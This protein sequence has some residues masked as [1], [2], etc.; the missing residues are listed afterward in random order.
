[1]VQ[2]AG[3]PEDGSSPDPELF[4]SYASADLDRA[5]ALQARLSGAGF[6]V[7]FD[8]ARLRPGCNWHQEIESACEAASVVVPLLTPHWKTSEWTRFET[9]GHA[10]ILALLAEGTPDEI[11]TP[12][13]KGKQAIS[14]DPL[15]ANDAAWAAL[16]TAL[17]DLLAIPRP[18]REPRLVDLPYPANPYFAGRD[19]ELVRIHEELHEAPAASL[20]QGRVRVLVGMG[21]IGKTTLANEYARRFWRLYPQI[22]WIDARRG[23]QSEFALIFDEFF[24]E[25]A[26]ATLKPEEKAAQALAELNGPRE[27]LLVIDNAEDAGSVRPWLPR[28]ATSGCRTLIT[29]RFS[30]WAQAGD[31]RTISLDVLQPEPSRR[32]LLTRTGRTADAAE[33]D[34]CD[35][36]A[37][38]LGYLPLALEQAAA[39]VG[40]AGSGASFADY[41]RLY[42]AAAGDLLA[43]GEL[44]STEYPDPVITTWQTSLAKL[45]PE[46]RAVLRL[47][48][49]L[50]DTPI[51]RSLVLDGA[52]DVLA[53]AASFG[54]VAPPAGE[55]ATELR[56]RDAVIGLAR[57]SMV[58][59]GTDT[60]FRVHGLVQTVERLRAAADGAEAAARGHALAR[61]AVAFPNAFRDPSCWPLCRLLLPH[62]RALSERLGER[63]MSPEQAVL[64]NRTG[65]FLRET[66][67]AAAALPLYRRALESREQMLGAEHPDTL[68]SVSNLAFCLLTLGD[69]AAALPLYRRALD[70][71]ETV[72]GAGDPQTLTCL[73]NVASCLNSLGDAKAALPLFVRA[74]MGLEHVLGP[75][76]PDTLDSLNNLAGCLERLGEPAAAL[77]LYRRAVESSER[78]LGAEH[79]STLISVNNLADCLQKLGDGPAALALYVRTLKSNARVLGAE[80][81]QTLIC[82]NNLGLCLASCGDAAAAVPLIGRAAEIAE[83]TLGTDHPITRQLRASLVQAGGH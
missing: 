52:G 21:G 19:A 46:S 57:Y 48:A 11:L 14:L 78:V 59:D 26:I 31:T 69:A 4:I 6:R 39:Y 25:R 68:I 15:T 66:G 13:L 1:M 43:R 74:L 2:T 35:T 51:P 83:R 16:A 10:A 76:H 61:L 22:L 27:R 47:C 54:P 34:A 7:W 60:S 17:H 49:W 30:G 23:Y 5:A 65:N 29:S 42:Q 38:E 18:E 73:N 58:L 45:A 72:L 33:R 40:Q 9:Y 53:L 64:L 12:P 77:P 50:A 56:M 37:G 3:T 63:F 71:S 62:Q 24:P 44:G 36:L 67:D 81:P 41:L 82:V 32:F 20:T 55:A 80:H 79:P 75:E 70:S 28:R 8:K